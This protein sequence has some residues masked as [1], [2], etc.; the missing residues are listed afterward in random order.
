MAFLRWTV[1]GGVAG[2][3]TEG[4]DGSDERS[5]R[6][7]ELWESTMAMEVASVGILLTF[8]S[9]DIVFQY[10]IKRYPFVARLYNRCGG[11]TI[12]IVS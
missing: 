12:L 7:F 1:G 10:R 9:V 6:F 2:W 5:F 11:R 4:G 8:N 3:T